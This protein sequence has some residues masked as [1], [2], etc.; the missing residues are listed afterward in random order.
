MPNSDERFALMMAT[1]T[2]TLSV[3]CK[4]LVKSK[5]IDADELVNELH[6]LLSQGLASSPQGMGPLKHLLALIEE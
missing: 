4:L 2:A 3:I 6:A 1:Q 5:A